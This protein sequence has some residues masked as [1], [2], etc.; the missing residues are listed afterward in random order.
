MA[1]QLNYF[2]S[3]PL[4]YN[5]NGFFGGHYSVGIRSGDIAGALTAGA[6]GQLI[7]IR[8]QDT[9]MLMVPLRLELQVLCKAYSSGNS[10]DLAVYIARNFTTNASG[11]GSVTYSQPSKHQNAR[12]NQSL[13]ISNG[14]FRVAGTTGLTPGTQTLDATPIATGAV[15]ITA[16]QQVRSLT[17]ITPPDGGEHPIVIGNNEGLIVRLESINLAASNTIA[18]YGRFIWAE[19]PQGAF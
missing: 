5:V 11:S 13:L 1:N 9:R 2:G 4:N 15:E 16:V 3:N 12:M 7:S 10:L 19:C 18:V 8:W 6:N 17:M 14:E